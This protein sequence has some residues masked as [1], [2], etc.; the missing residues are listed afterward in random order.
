MTPK[1]KKGAKRSTNLLEII[2]K[3]ANFFKNMGLLLNTMS[4]SLDQNSVA[5]RRNHTLI[6][7][8]RCI[9]SNTVLKTPFEL[10]KGWRPRCLSEVRIYNPQKNKLDLRTISGYFIGYSK[11]SKGYRFYYPTHNP[12]IVESRNAKILENDLISGSD[13]DIGQPSGLSDT[14]IMMNNNW[15]N[16]IFLN[17][18]KA[19]LRRSNKVK[20]DYVMYVQES[21]YNIGAENDLVKHFHK[22]RV[23]K[24]QTCGI[25]P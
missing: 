13:Q 22:P 6:D 9:R 3:Y 11:K 17:K 14:M 21:Y 19:A 10:L 12:R 15:L 8:V 7:M 16:N 23:L 25:M 18:N 5:K 4:N 20:N 2:Y 24:N 1:S